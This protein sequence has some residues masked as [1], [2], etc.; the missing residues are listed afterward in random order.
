L[1]AVQKG[2]VLP[3]DDNLLA[4]IGPRQVDGLETLARILHPEA[5]E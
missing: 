1:A 4:R 5:F 2:R 3:F